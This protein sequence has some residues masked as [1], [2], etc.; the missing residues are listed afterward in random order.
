M[1]ADGSISHVRFHGRSDRIPA[2]DH[3]TLM[4]DLTG[5]PWRHRA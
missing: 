2:L 5:T 3:K 4:R 1:A